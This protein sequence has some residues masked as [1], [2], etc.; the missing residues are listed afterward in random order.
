MVIKDM[1]E[2]NVAPNTIMYSALISACEKGGQWQEAPKIFEDTKK[3]NVAPDTYT[4]S[5]LISACGK[6][7][8]SGRRR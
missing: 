3:C 7:E 8:D 5:A 1:K 4:Y 6:A 2:N